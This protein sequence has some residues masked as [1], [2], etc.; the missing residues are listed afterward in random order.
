MMDPFRKFIRSGFENI[1]FS[2]FLNEGIIKFRIQKRFYF[3]PIFET[4]RPYTPPPPPHRPQ[5]LTVWL[6]KKKFFRK[7]FKC[8]LASGCITDP[9]IRFVCK[10]H[11]SSQKRLLTVKKLFLC[12]YRIETT[13]FLKSLFFK[14]SFSNY[15]K[16][17]KNQ[18]N[19]QN[20]TTFRQI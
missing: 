20:F 2:C 12:M 6:F 15:R 8:N 16:S 1:N 17:L 5:W 19:H 3:V 14:T 11:I 10:R 13:T 9:S 4:Q 18:E 7:Q